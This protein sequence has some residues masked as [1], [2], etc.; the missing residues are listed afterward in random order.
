MAIIACQLKQIREAGWHI[1]RDAQQ[2]HETIIIT[3]LK[4]LSRAEAL[5]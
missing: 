2:G 3:S 4:T 1:K 5:R